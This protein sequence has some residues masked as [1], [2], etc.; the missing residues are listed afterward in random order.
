MAKVD[1]FYDPA[2]LCGPVDRRVVNFYEQYKGH[3]LDASYLRH[4]E[5]YHGG[6]PGKQYFD[7]SD[8]KTYRIG[9]FLT[10]VD[11]KSE[12]DPPYRPSWEFPPQDIRIDWSI[13]NPIDQEGM[14]CRALF[15]GDQL[16]TFA[17]LY[18]GSVHPDNMGL[19]EGIID[20]VSFMYESKKKRPRV[21]VWL[22]RNA[23]KEFIRWEKAGGGEIR[24]SEFTI[25]VAPH[26]TAFLQM[27]RS[28]P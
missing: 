14:S 4:V 28:E 6:I 16:L 22:A 10:I 7:A 3:R 9:R 15:A 25:P 26:F 21:V 5:K 19:T 17:A 11:E 8:E 2:S 24:Y 23:T 20:L 27:L 12:L 13:L 1:L 18:Y